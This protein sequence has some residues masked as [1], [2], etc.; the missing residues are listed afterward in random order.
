[1]LDDHQGSSISAD[2][3]ARP[4]TAADLPSL[5]ARPA[6]IDI[7]NLR[8]HKPKFGLPISVAAHG[9]QCATL[10]LRAGVD[11]E[12]VFACL[13]HDIGLGLIRA[14]HGW[15]GAQLLEPYVSERVA[16]GIRYH[17]ALRFYADREAGYAY[18]ELYVRMFG[19]DY[20]P[21][22]YI[23][24]AYRHARNHPW[25][26]HARQITLFDDYGFDTSAPFSLEP[27]IDIIGRHF[28]QPAEGLGNDASATAHMWRTIIEPNKLL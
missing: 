12:T 14:D 9:V 17:Q 1:M 15:W 22:E 7:F 21:P 23:A 3:A 25:Y 8:L 2:V 4:A 19:A 5:P 11:E 13:V 10:A 6:L 27:F 24:A 18:P 28:R 26:G 20:Q 16:W